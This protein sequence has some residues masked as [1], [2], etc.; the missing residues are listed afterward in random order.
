M[1]NQRRRSNYRRNTASLFSSHERL[2]ARYRIAQ[3]DTQTGGRRVHF[4]DRHPDNTIVVEQ[5]GFYPRCVRCNMFARTVGTTHQATEMC[6]K[7]TS[8]R[9][10]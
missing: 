7:A 2:N 6:K 1:Q 4:R 9:E 10:K 8:R 3:D 5:K